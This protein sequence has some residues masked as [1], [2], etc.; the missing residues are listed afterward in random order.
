MKCKH[1]VA[2][3]WQQGNDPTVEVDGK[4][5]LQAGTGRWA[6]SQV[7]FQANKQTGRQ[8]QVQMKYFQ[9]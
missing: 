5:G 7:S 3:V 9:G 2:T 4:K 1:A 6:D 8:V